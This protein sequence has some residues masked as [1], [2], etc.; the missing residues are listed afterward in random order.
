MDENEL[1][2]AEDYVTRDEETGTIEV[3]HIGMLCDLT[4]TE[5]EAWAD[6]EGPDSGV[7]I[8]HYYVTTDESLNAR[9]GEDQGHLDIVV[10]DED[11]EDVANASIDM[12]DSPTWSER[13]RSAQ[14]DEGGDENRD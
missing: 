13:D 6:A 11:G 5:P 9:I 3:D 2:E 12:S 7:G 14:D 4:G 10:R 8:D 1:K